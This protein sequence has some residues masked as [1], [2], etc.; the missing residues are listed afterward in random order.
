V[1]EADVVPVRCVRG[2]RRR[3]GAAGSSESRSRSS[4]V[5]LLNDFK[6]M[7]RDRIAVEVAPFAERPFEK[8]MGAVAAC[9]RADGTHHP[10]LRRIPRR[11]RRAAARMLG[12]AAGDFRAVGDFDQLHALVAAIADSIRGLGAVWVYD[13]ALAIG[14]ALN[15]SPDAIYL[16]AGTAEAARYFGVRGERCESQDWP[17][18]FHET[19]M[20]AD[21]FESFLCVCKRELKWI[22][23]RSGLPQMRRHFA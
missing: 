7:D 2:R 5:A 14:A 19:G 10:H 15:L 3:C 20:N 16:H 8:V 23:T 11:A 18:E 21:D 6:R 17:S 22:H 9:K 13:T 12:S 4:L 1:D